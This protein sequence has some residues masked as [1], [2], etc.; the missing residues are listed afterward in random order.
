MLC[1]DSIN[2][3]ANTITFNAYSALSKDYPSGNR[4]TTT[5]NANA[6]AVDEENIIV[7]LSKDTKLFNDLLDPLILFLKENSQGESIKKEEQQ[8]MTAKNVN[9]PL[10]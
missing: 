7:P 2:S 3:N 8:K 9:Q 6:T 5:T 4:G 1:K 10:A